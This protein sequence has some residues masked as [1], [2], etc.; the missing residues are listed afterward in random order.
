MSTS[1]Q[2]TV[3]DL[4]RELQW[5]RRVLDTRLKLYFGQDA[6]HQDI[7]TIEPPDLSDSTSNWAR[8]IKKHQMSFPERLALV[9]ALVPH[10]DPR[11]LDVLFT[12]NSQFNRPFTEFGGRTDHPHPGFIPTGETVLFLLAG[13][14]LTQRI[15]A[16]Q[17]L[18]NDHFFFKADLITLE[19]AQLWEPPMSGVLTVSRKVLT[20]LLHEDKRKLVVRED[21][22]GKA[23]IKEGE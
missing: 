11:Q 15:A 12:Q 19:N 3:Q 4:E 9:L 13:N 16:M 22:S 8:L 17:L 6:E 5:F 23:D 10:L 7:S 2:A 1:L 20:F 18:H 14:D 21:L